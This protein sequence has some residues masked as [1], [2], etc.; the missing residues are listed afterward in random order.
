MDNTICDFKTAYLKAIEKNPGI[1]FPQSQYGFFTNLE[2]IEG[3]I[4]AVNYLRKYYDVYILTRPSVMNPLCY[5]EKRIWIEKYFGLEFCDRLILCCNKSLLKG[6]YLIDDN[7]HVGFEGEHIH[8]GQDKFDTW[9][10]IFEHLEYPKSLIGLEFLKVRDFCMRNN[11]DFRVVKEDN[12]NYCITCDLIPEK[13]S[14]S[15]K[16]GVVTEIQME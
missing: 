14:L 3:A 6:N 13:L 1:Q 4:N 7:I 12:K 9:Q 10:R 5:T 15:L 11:I 8:F 2:P 16:Q